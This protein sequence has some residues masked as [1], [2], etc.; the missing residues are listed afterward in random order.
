[1]MNIF[2]F[3]FLLLIVQ[4]GFSQNLSGVWRGAMIQNGTSLENATLIYFDINATT[5]SVEGY[6]RN[7]L[8][9][10]E[11]FALK[12]IKGTIKK[13]DIELKE[14]V[15]SKKTSPS[16][17]QWCRLICSLKYN[18]ETGYLEGTYTSSDCRNAVGKIIAYRTESKFAMEEAPTESHHW[19]D[20][21]ISDINKGFKAPEIRKMERENFKFQPIYFDYDKD[22]IRPEFYAFLS[23]MIKVVEGHTDLRVKVTGHTD[24]DGSDAYNDDLSKRRAESII[25]FFTDRGLSRDR[26][27][28]DFKGEK[29]PVDNNDT[30]EGKQHNRRVDFKFI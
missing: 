6:S 23:S 27:E 12:K 5:T 8:Y 22:V 17:V 25:K 29:Q 20:V 28:F 2:R 3:A 24:A 14:I 11:T 7:E 10:T 9:N 19:F 30:P 16:R 1:M 18:E 15:V 21:F 26:L 13:N 4:T